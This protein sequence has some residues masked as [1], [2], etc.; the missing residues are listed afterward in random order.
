MKG[1]L[2]GVRETFPLDT[3]P[4]FVELVGRMWAGEPGQRPTV[5][6]LVIELEAMHGDF[7]E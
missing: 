5:N 2:K 3:P 1:V 4:D 7:A 6:E